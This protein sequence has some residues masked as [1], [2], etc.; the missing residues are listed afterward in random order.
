MS[1]AIESFRKFGGKL[2]DIFTLKGLTVPCLMLLTFAAAANP[3][4]VFSG[5]FQGF[6]FDPTGQ[7]SLA[8]SFNVMA[9]GAG[10]A[11]TA[12]VQV[13]NGIGAAY[14]AGDMSLISDSLFTNFTNG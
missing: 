3:A 11:L 14:Q 12:G 10:N 7:F 5:F 1:G 2:G 6:L 8:H 13:G 9:T 4:M